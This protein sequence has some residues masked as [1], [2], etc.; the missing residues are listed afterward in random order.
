VPTAAEGAL[1]AYNSVADSAAQTLA[2]SS[3][4]VTESVGTASSDVL[5]AYKSALDSA[6]QTATDQV[7]TGD[8]D[9]LQALLS[10][11][12]DK[13][14]LV[15]A[16]AAGALAV[17]VL[18]LVFGGGPSAKVVNASKAMS[19]LGS[20]EKNM[21]FVDLRSGNDIS[22]SG[23]PDLKSVGK[24][25]VRVPVT[26]D[27]EMTAVEKIE[28][29]FDKF[30]SVVLMDAVGST[31]PKVGKML[32]AKKYDVAFV[33]DGADGPNGWKSSG[34]PWKE[35]VVIIEALK[36]ATSGVV[37]SYREDPL[38]TVLTFLGTLGVGTLAFT[39]Y[40]SL[41]EAFALL[42]AGSFMSRKLLFYEDRKKTL[43]QFSWFL[44]EKEA[45]ADLKQEVKVFT[46]Q[47][48]SKP[49]PKPDSDEKME[50]K[51]LV[52]SRE[53]QEEAKDLLNE[54]KERAA[55]KPKSEEMV[56]NVIDNV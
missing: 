23:S 1:D 45:P 15:A 9:Q 18:A 36:G 43:Q 21:A 22:A 39:E 35:P 54:W 37:E 24:R 56:E 7:G 49:A 12:Q 38:S 42:A 32:A 14:G 53:D 17:P 8:P 55:E 11:L 33:R 5:D 44:K 30:D 41:L 16:L 2:E 34:M 13:P 52:F 6:V 40:D 29:L 27:Q 3:Q 31:A 51:D 47:I 46:D 26:V 4:A 19:M 25:I 48:S 10:S 28:K 20:D 50:R